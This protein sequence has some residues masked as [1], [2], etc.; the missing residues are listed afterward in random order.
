MLQELRCE[1]SASDG[2]RAVGLVA[3]GGELGDGLRATDDARVVARAR[4]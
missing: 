1:R 4:T 2:D 3:N